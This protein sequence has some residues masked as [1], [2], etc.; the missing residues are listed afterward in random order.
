[1]D[2]LAGQQIKGYKLQE[3]IAAGGFGAVYCAYQSTVGR[4]VAVKVSLPGLA[5]KPDFILRF[6]AEAQLI[7][8]LEHMNI[9]PLHD[10]WRDPDGANLVIRYLW[11]GSLH[12]YIRKHGTFSIEDAFNLSFR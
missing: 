5:N 1:V 4:E 10:Y 2:N 7:A 6:E 8:R 11:G 12:D 3:W 9:V